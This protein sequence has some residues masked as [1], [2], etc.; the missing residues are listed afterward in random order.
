MDVLPSALQVLLA[1]LT[2]AARRRGLSDSAWARLAQL[3]RESL[4]RLRRRHDCDWATI[5][6]LSRVV[7][8]QLRALPAG[9]SEL[10]GW[11]RA[12]EER[13]YQLIR[14]GDLDP[15]TWRAHG[16]AFF[17]A[18]IAV[19]LAGSRGYPRA[20]LLQLAESLHPGISEPAVANLWLRSSPIEP[21][22]FFA[23]LEGGQR[24]AA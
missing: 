22:R 4:S 17:M 24:H 12:Q 3:P 20:Q 19:L 14:S 11:S 8:M 7:G 13:V 9:N 21:S 18:G 5:E 2:A 16:A 23:Q 1:D 10:E 15:A 6:R